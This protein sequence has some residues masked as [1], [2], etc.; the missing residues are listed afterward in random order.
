MG[1]FLRSMLNATLVLVI[2]CAG[3]L[4]WLVYKVDAVSSS[5]AADVDM[6]LVEA[7]EADVRDAIDEIHGLRDDLKTMNEQVDAMLADP[8]SLVTPEMR[9]E[10]EEINAYADEIDQKLDE[11]TALDQELSDQ[12]IREIGKSLAE[13][14]VEARGC[15]AESDTAAGS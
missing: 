5:V 2:I 4:V 14:I 11:L 12:Q 13:V 3:L 7:V 9:R 15:R 8:D 1:D 10:L 6:R